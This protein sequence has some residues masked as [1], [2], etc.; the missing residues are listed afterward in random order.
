MRKQARIRGGGRPAGRAEAARPLHKQNAEPEMM[1]EALPK[2]GEASG[3]SLC[4]WN[5]DKHQAAW[6]ALAAHES[7]FGDEEIYSPSKT[8][9]NWDGPA[10][11]PGRLASLGLTHTNTV[12]VWAGCVCLPGVNRPSPWGGGGGLHACKSPSKLQP[13]VGTRPAAPRIRAPLEGVVRSLCTQ[14]STLSTPPHHTHAGFSRFHTQRWRAE[15]AG[16]N[17][18]AGARLSLRRDYEGALLKLDHSR[19]DQ[20]HWALRFRPS[21]LCGVERGASDPELSAVQALGGT[22]AS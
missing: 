11:D 17:K 21:C 7:P 10:K 19:D 9:Y 12:A 2:R 6:A 22:R 1:C 5:D 14:L 4:L 15:R 8:I 13:C 3:C 18:A 16:G 20:S